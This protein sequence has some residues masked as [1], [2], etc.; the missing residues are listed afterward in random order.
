MRKSFNAKT[1]RREAA[2]ELKSFGG[3]LGHH[4][5]VSAGGGLAPFGFRRVNIALNYYG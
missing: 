3:G 4:R 1:Q 2:K 5:K